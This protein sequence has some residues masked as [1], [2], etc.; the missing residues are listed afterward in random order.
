MNGLVQRIVSAEIPPSR[1]ADRIWFRESAFFTFRSLSSSSEKTTSFG[2]SLVIWKS[3]APISDGA[4]IIIW[5]ACLGKA[6]IHLIESKREIHI[7]PCCLQ[8]PHVLEGCR[9]YLAFIASLS[10][11]F[12]NLA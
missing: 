1:D 3:A 12:K 7:S 11:C 9:V 4:N 2:F 5:E 8:L 6:L 10:R